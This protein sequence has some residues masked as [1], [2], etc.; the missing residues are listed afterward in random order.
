MSVAFCSIVTVSSRLGQISRAPEEEG[1]W[2]SDPPSTKK[3]LK[4]QKF[5]S[6]QKTRIIFISTEVT[7]WKNSPLEYFWQALLPS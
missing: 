5:N 2:A 4:D 3:Y 7:F 1:R 6:V